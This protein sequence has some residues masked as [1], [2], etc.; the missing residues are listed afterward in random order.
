MNKE[1]PTIVVLSN[2]INPD[3]TLKEDVRR[4][5]DGS[6]VL[7]NVPLTDRLTMSG[8]CTT[9]KEEKWKQI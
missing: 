6:I 4:R 2:D 5:V 3:G 1:Y 9:L 8:K 7:Y